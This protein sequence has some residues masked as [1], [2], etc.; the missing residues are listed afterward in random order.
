MEIVITGSVEEI[1][2]LVL[3]VQERRAETVDEID[4]RLGFK[5]LTRPRPKHDTDQGA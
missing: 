2:A 3:A 1:A 4:A 5:A